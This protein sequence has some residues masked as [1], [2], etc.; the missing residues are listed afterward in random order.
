MKFSVLF[1][2]KAIKKE[3]C[4]EMKLCGILVNLKS[5]LQ[6][7]GKMDLSPQMTFLSLVYTYP[8]Q[9]CSSIIAEVLEHA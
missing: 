6:E 3:C 9:P 5:T 1:D 7:V 8:K 2:F 4:S